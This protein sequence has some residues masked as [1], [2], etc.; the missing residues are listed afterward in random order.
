MSRAIKLTDEQGRYWK[1]WL[2]EGLAGKY[3][4]GK[5]LFAAKQRH[6]DFERAR[7]NEAL[8]QSIERHS[9]HD[10]MSGSVGQVAM[11]SKKIRLDENGREIR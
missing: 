4:T 5:Q 11:L 8:A 3:T 1:I 2:R 9:I 10:W 6:A 7:G